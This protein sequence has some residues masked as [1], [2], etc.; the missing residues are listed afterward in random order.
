MNGSAKTQTRPTRAAV[1]SAPRSGGTYGRGE[2]VDVEVRFNKEVTVSGQPQLELTIGSNA[3]RAARSGRSTASQTGTAPKKRLAQFVSAANERLHFRYVVQ[4]ADDSLGGGITIAADALRLNGASITDA[5]GEAVAAQHLRLDGAEVVPGDPVDGAVSE[6]ATVERVAVTSAPQAD[7]T[8]RVGEAIVVEVRFSTE[9]AVSGAPQ[10]EL[11]I[12]A[13][14]TTAGAAR[15]ASFVAADRDTLVFRYPVQ[16]GDADRDG[17]AIPA[18][19]LHLNGGTIVDLLGEAAELGLEQAQIIIPAHQVD[20]QTADATPPA[21]AS[22]AIVSRPPA[23]SYVYGD[24]VSVTVTFNEPV[25]VTGSPQLALHVGSAVRLA[26]IS[27]QAGQAGALSDTVEF[28]YAVRPGDRD[29]DGIAHPRG[30][31]AP[32]RAARSAT[33]PATTP[34]CAAARCSPPRVRQSIRR[35]GSGAGR[36]TRQPAA[37]RG[38]RFATALS[39]CTTMTWS[40][41]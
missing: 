15:R 20:G 9:V 3:Q 25:T 30:R 13:T 28:V 1:T 6:P 14:G 5:A 10:L 16:A 23:G 39:R 4:A 19:A 35:W 36:R 21:V 29:D 33:A 7:R 34:T 26:D 12:D 22:V 18:N 24:R 8:Y 27:G 2:S 41:P 17:I 11:A 38:A 37:G 40:W 32:R 31:A